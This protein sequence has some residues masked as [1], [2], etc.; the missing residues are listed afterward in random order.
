MD[1]DGHL[2]DSDKVFSGMLGEH[3]ERNRLSNLYSS[4]QEEL[5]EANKLLEAARSNLS[6]TNEKINS[7]DVPVKQF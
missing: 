7:L 2:E 3:K 4:K 6:V 1:L 5:G